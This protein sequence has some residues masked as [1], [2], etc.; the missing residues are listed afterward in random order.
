MPL[1]LETRQELAI[2]SL[3]RNGR[4]TL[5]ARGNS[6]LPSVVPGASLTVVRAAP[7]CVAVGD[8][9]LT[10]TGNQLRLHRAVRLSGRYLV[11]RGDR[12]LSEDPPV[13]WEQVLGKVEPTPP[14]HG[15]VFSWLLRRSDR[16]ARLAGRVCEAK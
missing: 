2:Q 16:L 1:L 13:T 8:V 14:Q 11:T 12:H 7:G 4:L 15:G 3:E 10:R 9:V 5:R 6:M